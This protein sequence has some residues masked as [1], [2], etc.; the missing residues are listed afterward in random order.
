[1][2]QLQ[3]PCKTCGKKIDVILNWET[4]GRSWRGGY[5]QGLQEGK[6]ARTQA[7]YLGYPADYPI[8]QSIDE[9]VIA[10]LLGIADNY[11]RGFNDGG[12]CGPQ[13]AYGTKLALD[14][15]FDQGLIR[16][17]WQTNARGWF[18][19]SSDCAR[20]LMF[21][22][23]SHPISPPLPANQYDYNDFN[24]AGKN[25]YPFLGSGP[26]PTP[27][28]TGKKMF[29][30]FQITDAASDQGRKATFSCDGQTYHWMTGAEQNLMILEAKAQGIPN[31]IG[32]VTKAQLGRMTLI[33]PNPGI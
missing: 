28:R 9:G 27:Q 21:Q 6:D 1:M 13:G 26:A 5:A 25:P 29:F 22:R 12:G 20:A 33:G 10:S 15:F 2:T 17:G 23:T 18:A 14:S 4:T 16:V 31:N 11:Q 8:I 7:R 32:H 3:T 30:M 19:N 24:P